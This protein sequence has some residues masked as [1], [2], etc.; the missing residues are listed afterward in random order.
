MPS[1][2]H[3]LVSSHKMLLVR[4][5]QTFIFVMCASMLHPV[6]RIPVYQLYCVGFITSVVNIIRSASVAGEYKKVQCWFGCFAALQVMVVLQMAYVGIAPAVHS[7]FDWATNLST[8]VPQ[9][10][11]LDLT[12]M[13]LALFLTAHAAAETA[14]Y[15]SVVRHSLPM[16]LLRAT[17]LFAMCTAVYLSFRRQAYA[18]YMLAVGIARKSC[19]DSSRA[20][21]ASNDGQAVPGKAPF[22]GVSMAK[23]GLQASHPTREA[24]CCDA[25]KAKQDLQAKLPDKATQDLQDELLDKDLR[26]KL[27]GKDITHDVLKQEHSEGAQPQHAGRREAAGPL[28]LSAEHGQ[29]KPQ[30]SS[31]NSLPLSSA[32]LPL[33]AQ[34]RLSKPRLSDP[35]SLQPNS[36]PRLRPAEH[37]PG[38]PQT[39]NLSSLQRSSAP[40]LLAAQQTLSKPRLSDPSSL[41]PMSISLPLPAQHTP[42]EPQR[43]SSSVQLKPAPFIPSTRGFADP[44][45]CQ[46]LIRATRAMAGKPCQQYY[47]RV[48][49]SGVPRPNATQQ[50]VQQAYRLAVKM[51]GPC[52]PERV[53]G[54][55]VQQL[56]CRLQRYQLLLHGETPAVRAGCL[57][58]SFGVLPVDSTGHGLSMHE[59]CQHTAATTQEWARQHG[60]M[61]AEDDSLTVQACHQSDWGIA[62]SPSGYS[63][64]LHTPFLIV[65]PSNQDEAAIVQQCAPAELEGPALPQE[66]EASCQFELTIAAPPDFDQLRGWQCAADAPEELPEDDGVKSRSLSL[67]ASVDGQF[68]PT[69]VEQR[70]MASNG[71]RVA[72]AR[73][74]L[75]GAASS[76]PEVV[77]LELWAAGSLVCSYSAMLLPSSC[78][79]ALAELQGM[80]QGDEGSHEFVRDL[81][82]WAHFLALCKSARQQ[83]QQGGVAAVEDAHMQ[84]AEGAHWE[85][86]A[87]MSSV[88]K[89]LLE[90]SLS[91][92]MLAVAGLLLEGLMDFPFCMPASALLEDHEPLETDQRASLCPDSSTQQQEP[93]TAPAVAATRDPSPASQN[94]SRSGAAVP[95]TPAAESTLSRSHVTE[96]PSRWEAAGTQAPLWTS[97]AHACI[98]GFGGASDMSCRPT[99]SQLEQPQ[100]EHCLADQPSEAGYREWGANFSKQFLNIRF[101]CCCFG[102]LFALIREALSG[103]P[104]KA[105]IMLLNFMPY[106]V[107]FYKPRAGLQIAKYI[108]LAMWSSMGL[109]LCY[110]E[111]NTRNMVH[112]NVDAVVLVLFFSPSL[113]QAGLWA[114]IRERMLTTVV[115][116]LL[117]NRLH[118]WR[119]LLR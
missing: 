83:Q 55:S 85:Q 98:K 108:H 80:E 38:K 81:V 52:L 48:E 105:A 33:A 99:C 58:L 9:M 76:C 73:M 45:L 10:L 17:W 102:S 101:N 78:S 11:V 69:S 19:T 24:A 21:C 72:Q 16:A 1:Y 91:E 117:S 54:G 97:A 5:A 66:Q 44:A 112:L 111:A 35:S 39:R 114:L 87:L 70:S 51:N 95:S 62:S 12:S 30:L 61:A 4:W 49:Q 92:G 96:N 75:P 46:A 41:Q 34:Q 43:A 25:S 86:L 32:P 23:Q 100:H 84:A 14:F 106:L 6:G 116:A 65:G 109:G 71:E 28:L 18:E 29:G 79:D 22:G 107:K 68:V 31:S 47:S 7:Y 40:L 93:P 104:A 63:M 56:R 67:L 60:L 26:A 64:A 42:G 113:D 88:G 36:V 115:F 13:K 57:V 3:W 103:E 37:T 119:P 110:M 77:V 20:D 8:L 82:N 59:V 118:T 2:P 74:S 15:L 89:D 50:C 53:P 90:Y 94:P 27:P